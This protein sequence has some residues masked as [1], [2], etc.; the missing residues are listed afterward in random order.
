MLVG[1]IP[2]WA[3]DILSGME[4]KILAAAALLF[5][6]PSA[7]EQDG[8]KHP[9]PPPDAPSLRPVQDP[10][11]TEVERKDLL[12]RFG[13]GNPLQG[14]YRL[15]NVVRGRVQKFNGSGYLSIGRQHISLHL[16]GETNN[17]K[18]PSIQTGFHRYRIVGDKIEMTAL[19]GFR[20]NSSGDVIIEKAGRSETRR[21]LRLG[22]TLRIFSSSRDYMEFVR[23]E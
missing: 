12:Q 4:K 13:K 9:V 15:Q 6:L 1:A 20:N 22:T 7:Q 2:R 11:R 17:P 18:L 23:I 19:V 16:F 5:V 3:A 8:L 10:F 21:F 14:F